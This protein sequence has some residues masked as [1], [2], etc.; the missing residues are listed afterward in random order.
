MQNMFSKIKLRRKTHTD[1]IMNNYVGLLFTSTFHF[2]DSLE[3]QKFGHV[4]IMAKKCSKILSFYCFLGFIKETPTTR[5]YC[6]T[7]KNNFNYCIVVIS[8]GK[9]TSAS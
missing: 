9:K 1:V 6:F 2:C 7:E 8:Y 3:N 5:L 4:R